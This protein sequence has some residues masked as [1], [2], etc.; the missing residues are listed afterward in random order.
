MWAIWDPVPEFLPEEFH[1][2]KG[3]KAY[4]KWA[5]GRP[6]IQAKESELQ[7]PGTL[8]DT[9]LAYGLALRDMLKVVNL[10]PGST[11]LSGVPGYFESS[12][13]TIEVVDKLSYACSEMTTSL[14]SV[15]GGGETR[16]QKRKKMESM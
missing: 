16:R 8:E 7:R 9:A 13:F 2:D 10:E 12:P 15:Y 3:L 14:N 1:T 5:E 4:M 6:F 11:A